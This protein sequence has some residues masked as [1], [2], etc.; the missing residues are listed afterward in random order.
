MARTWNIFW[1]WCCKHDFII[2]KDFRFNKV[3][4]VHLETWV[5]IIILHLIEVCSCELLG[6]NWK[7]KFNKDQGSVLWDHS[8][9]STQINLL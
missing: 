8:V 9:T 2:L 4:K 1:K 7:E 5:S 3:E 6:L